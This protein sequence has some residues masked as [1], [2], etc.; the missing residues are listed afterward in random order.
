MCLLLLSKCAKY[1]LLITNTIFRQA[2][3]TS[4]MHLCSKQWH[5]IDYIITHERDS[6]DVVITK[7]MRGAEC[8]M[9]NR[10]IRSKL[11]IALQHHKRPKLIRLAFSTAILLSAKY[12]LEFRS[13]FDGEF[14]AIGLQ[15]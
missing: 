5:A 7:A 15:T 12:Q 14:E 4:W 10:L 2:G 11:N 13:N 9:D 6:S 8:W 1:N 3:K